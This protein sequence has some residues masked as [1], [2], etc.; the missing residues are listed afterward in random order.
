MKI[1][2]SAIITL[3]LLSC[4][5]LQKH[6]LAIR[7]MVDTI[8]F[9]SKAYQVDSIIARIHR[10]QGDRLNTKPTNES[11]LMAICPHDD[12]TYVGWQYAAVLQNIKAKTVFIFGV[13]HKAKRFNLENK[14]I[15]DSFDY[16]HGPYKDI[17]VSC[18]RDEII[19][20]M[21]SDMAEVHDS[22]QIVEHS[23]ESML[24][25]L[26]HFNPDVEIIPILVPYMSF[27]RIDKIAN[28]LA[29]A[30]NSVAKENQLEWGKDFAILITTDAVHYGDEDWGGK[31]YAPFGTDSIGYQNAIAHEHK[32]I[33]N[34]LTGHLTQQGIQKFFEYT[35]NPTDY[36]EYKW[37]WC[38]RYSIPLGL[39]T[40]LYLNGYQKGIPLN[41]ELIGYSTSIDHAPI[42][43][44]DIGMGKTAIANIH[45]WVGYASLGYK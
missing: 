33:N 20:K 36:R 45:H 30:I 15:F 21:P 40:A 44:E 41:G 29:E 37:T 34:C 22:M 23:I 27:A 25:I 11:F 43:V 4:S 16:W 14:L 18:L 19:K 8:G 10:L 26:Q 12:Y 39:S 42:E 2:L 1:K 7:Q 3:A 35:V 31:N 24:P 6:P 32:I 5:N 13:A 17:K 9:A 38:G 28:K